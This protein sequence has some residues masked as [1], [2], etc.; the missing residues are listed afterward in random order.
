MKTAIIS[1]MC[2]I[3][4]GGLGIFAGTNINN[5]NNLTVNIN[6]EDV[7]VTP[8]KYEELSEENENLKQQIA[9]LNNQIAESGTNNASNDSESKNTDSEG[10]TVNE[11]LALDLSAFHSNRAE[12]D[13]KNIKD[14]K[15]N[16]FTQAIILGNL[17]LIDDPENRTYNLE[18]QLDCQYSHLTG[19]VAFSEDNDGYSSG[20]TLFLDIY[21]DDQ[22]V[23]TIGP[24]DEKTDPI[25][26]DT[27]IPNP[28]YI[29][30]ITY[31]SDNRDWNYGYDIK[32][33]VDS[34]TFCN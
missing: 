20:E 8:K 26:L 19:M 18:Y 3:I 13:R 31:T 28:E 11:K 6:G 22:F 12:F 34:L 27:P 24:I 15:G 1:G 17:K 30:F 29:E 10:K 5:S 7:S 2:T 16:K 33:I 25:P 32:L 9:D 4:A 21:A 23:K 14:R